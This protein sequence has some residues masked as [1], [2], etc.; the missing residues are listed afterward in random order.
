MRS[1]PLPIE[2]PFSLSAFEAVDGALSALLY[3]GDFMESA[4]PRSWIRKSNILLDAC[5][6]AGMDYDT[7]DH[8]AWAAEYVCNAL[9]SA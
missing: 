7:D 4:D 6:D 8:A 5:V 1:K 9:V 2:K 3:A